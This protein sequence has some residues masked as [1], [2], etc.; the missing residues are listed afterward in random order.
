MAIKCNLFL[1]ADDACLVFQ[2]KMVDDIEKQLNKDFENMSYCFADFKLIIH[3]EKGKILSIRFASKHNI[4]K[5]PKLDIVNNN[6]IKQHSRVTDM[7]CILEKAMSGKSM[8]HKVI[9]KVQ[10]RLKFLCQKNKYLT[11]N[12]LSLL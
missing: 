8:T 7:S 5:V 3:F 9:C 10:A 2:N 12:L 1:Y 6:R 4:K 11:P